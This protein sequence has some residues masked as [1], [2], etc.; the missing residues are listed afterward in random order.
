MVFITNA[1]GGNSPLYAIR[2]D[3]KGDI[4]PA[5]GGKESD[6]LAWTV[7]RNGAY[8]QTPL[9]YGDYLYSCKDNGV[10][11]CYDAATG[12]RLYEERIGSGAG[13]FSASPVASHGN[14]YFTAEDGNVYVI[15]G[16][17]EF[18]VTATNALDEI[19]MATPALSDGALIFR[20]ARHL[21]RVGE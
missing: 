21:V 6:G 18:K 8:I 15:P 2:L 10:L 17:P 7:P 1:H 20:T 12:D 5:E 3:A 14:L 11:M 13:G 16:G 9:V 4:T 19:C